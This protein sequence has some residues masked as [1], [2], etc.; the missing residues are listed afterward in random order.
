MNLAMLD[1]RHS[2]RR[3]RSGSPSLRHPAVNG[4]E[5]PPQTGLGC[6]V[7]PLRLFVDPLSWVDALDEVKRLVKASLTSGRACRMPIKARGI[8]LRLGEDTNQCLSFT[9]RVVLLPF[10]Q[11]LLAQTQPALH[12]EVI[13]HHHVAA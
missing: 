6:Q 4:R 12:H 9:Y 3:A 1:K 13:A 8:G 10:P 2:P 11:F 7:L 5:G